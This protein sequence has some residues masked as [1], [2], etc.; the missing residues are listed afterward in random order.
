MAQLVAFRVHWPEA[1]G[2]FPRKAVECWFAHYLS[3]EQIKLSANKGERILAVAAELG[4]DGV[5]PVRQKSQHWFTARFP[6]LER[7]ALP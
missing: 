7:I 5:D 3:R 4:A 2:F 1:G 6:L